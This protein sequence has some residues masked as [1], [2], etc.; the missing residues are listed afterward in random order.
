MIFSDGFAA[1]NDISRY[2][3]RC[4]CYVVSDRLFKEIS[5]TENPQGIMAVCQKINFDAE[6]IIK[7]GGFYIIAEENERPGKSR[8]SHKNGICGR[9]RRNSIVKRQR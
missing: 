5:E 4:E 7:D 3:K 8:N 9:G 1:K 6:E 2:M